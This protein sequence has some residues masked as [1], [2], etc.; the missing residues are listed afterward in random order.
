MPELK[1]TYPALVT[2]FEEGGDP[3][4]YSINWDGFN[5]LLFHTLAKGG[6]EGVV[7]AGCTGAASVLDSDEQV[8]LVKYAQRYAVGNFE[9]DN[10]RIVIAGDGSNSTKEAINLAQKMEGKAGVD[11][12]LSISPY[13]NKPS[14]EGLIIHYTAIANSVDGNLILYSVPGRT[15]GKGIL[16][17]VAEELAKHPRI[18]G[19]KEASGDIDRIEEIIHR[20]R[21]EDFFVISGDDEMTI[22]IIKAGGVGVISVAANVVPGKVKSMVDYALEGNFADA[23]YEEGQLAGLCSALFPKK[24]GYNPSPNPVLCHYAL[25]KIKI[26]AGVTRLPLTDASPEEKSFMDGVLGNLG[27]IK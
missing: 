4:N 10:K 17:H 1:G 19:I 11:W 25:G 16:P 26:P 14:D 18:V 27:L 22:P 7:V 15:G 13:Q 5:K 6:V 24:R 21:N 2:P 8:E 3:V 20:T 12:H 9:E 23:Y